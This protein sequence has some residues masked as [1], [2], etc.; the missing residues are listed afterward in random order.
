[1]V[2]FIH[3]KQSNPNKNKQTLKLNTNM[4]D[5]HEVVVKKSSP[6]A[7]FKNKPLFST[8]QVD[9]FYWN[10]VELTVEVRD[11][12][13]YMIEK[14]LLSNI[15]GNI[16]AGELLGVMGGIGSGKT[17]FLN[18]LAGRIGPGTLTGK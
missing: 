14:T 1:M 17:T 7:L 10:N 5:L 16:V 2:I 13:N 12:D 4:L 6:P 9:L 15:S 8:P 18:T 3:N 11:K